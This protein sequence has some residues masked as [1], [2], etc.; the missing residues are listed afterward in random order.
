MSVEL[1]KRDKWFYMGVVELT[2][3]IR[4]AGLTDKLN[5][6]ND[7]LTGHQAPGGY[8]DPVLTD[9]KIDGRNCDIYHT[10]KKP[11]DSGNRIF[12]HIK[13]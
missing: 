3:E 7:V 13:E 6:F 10:N 4:K 5:H 12:I 2:E 8:G 11:G 1:G 9:V